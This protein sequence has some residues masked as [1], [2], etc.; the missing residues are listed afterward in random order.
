[1]NPSRRDPIAERDRRVPTMNERVCVGMCA[2]VSVCARIRVRKF[3]ELIIP[4]ASPDSSSRDFRGLSGILLSFGDICRNLFYKLREG[5]K[6]STES[7]SSSPS[8]SASSS[9]YRTMSRGRC[10]VC[11]FSSDVGIHLSQQRLGG[12]PGGLEANF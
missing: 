11:L 8:F 7:T 4:R 6:V 12:H 10:P 9:S 5:S 2:C 1:M 3:S